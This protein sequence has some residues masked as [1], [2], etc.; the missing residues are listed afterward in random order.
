MLRTTGRRA[1]GTALALVLLAPTPALARGGGSWSA[2]TTD[3]P[4]AESLVTGTAWQA[5]TVAPGISLREGARED[6]DG[7]VR[8]HVLR[9][10][11]TT[12]GVSVHPIAG[13]LASRTPLSVLA[14]GRKHL[15]A[16]TNAGF[17]DFRVGAP[18]GPVVDS[19]H[20]FLGTSTPQ[21][22]V[23]I[24]SLGRA[25][26]ATLALKAAATVGTAKH[27]LQG[28][29]MLTPPVGVSVYDGRWGSSPVPLPR[30]A[31]SRTVSA[32][33][34][35]SGVGAHVTVP[36]GGLLLVGRGSTARTWLAALRRGQ[37]VTY[38]STVTSPTAHPFRTAFAVGT[39]LV[40][41]GVA[42]HGLGCRADE[43]Q[44]ARTAIGFTASGAT[45][46]IA[47]VEDEPW[48]FVHG[49]DNDQMARLMHDLGAAQAFE[50]DG[51][52]STEMLAHITAASNSIC[53]RTNMS[54]MSCR[55]FPAD[56]QERPMPVGIGIFSS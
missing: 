51:S 2:Y 17:F 11:L 10:S 15:A 25:Q 42:R 53:Q 38:S 32:G 16:A 22:V 39:T 48:R 45:L 4:P 21:Q 3:C 6:S 50:L 44:P 12:V 24:N 52:G 19:G 20:A 47:E 28:L 5:K 35:S 54:G 30:D 36:A 56:G 31:T 55:T 37:R 13:H 9:V 40:A 1:A 8:M 33:A 43:P 26:A 34:V 27:A 46:V 18:T 7:Y 29:D 14:R 49:L 41:G 23:G